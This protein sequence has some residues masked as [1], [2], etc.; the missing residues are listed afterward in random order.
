[1]TDEDL[2]YEMRRTREEMERLN[3]NLKQIENNLAQITFN[4]N[5]LFNVIS[6]FI[7]Y[8]ME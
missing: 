3:E 2:M 4:L 6:D 7:K 8:L 1:M 5:A